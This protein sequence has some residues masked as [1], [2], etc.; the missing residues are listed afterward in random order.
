MA[1]CAPFFKSRVPSATGTFFKSHVPRAV[2]TF[3]KSHVPRAVG[4]FFEPRVP[5]AA[6]AFLRAWC[7]LVMLH[8][9]SSCCGHRP[10]F[11]APDE[12]SLE[13]NLVVP[14][15]PPY[16]AWPLQ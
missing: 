12:P 2:G 15:L 13:D 1:P 6:G 8:A 16:V 7:T 14:S 10:S 5:R 3:F 11:S 9:P 4:T